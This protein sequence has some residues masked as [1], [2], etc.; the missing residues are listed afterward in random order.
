MRVTVMLHLK[1]LYRQIG[2]GLEMK[3]IQK[4]GNDG[5]VVYLHVSRRAVLSY[6]E[7]VKY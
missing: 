1:G 3:R 7:S 2:C 4:E 5:K 6:R